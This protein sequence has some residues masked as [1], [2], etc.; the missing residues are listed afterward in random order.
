[1][2]ERLEAFPY[3]KSVERLLICRTQTPHVGLLGASAL[4]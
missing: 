4:D 1:M 2:R 3:R